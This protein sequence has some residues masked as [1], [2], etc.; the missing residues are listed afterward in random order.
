MTPI[1]ILEMH[2]TKMYTQQVY[3]EKLMKVAICNLN[4]TM[5]QKVVFEYACIRS[6]T[7]VHIDHMI[8][9]LSHKTQAA[10][11]CSIQG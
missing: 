7:I 6:G 1:D 10:H 9:C 8:S 2:G 3:K 11:K 4:K 5:F